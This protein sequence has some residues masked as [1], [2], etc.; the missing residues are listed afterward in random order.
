MAAGVAMIVLPW[1][2]LEMRTVLSGSMEPRLGQGDL[3]VAWPVRADRIEPGDVILF[4]DGDHAVA[5]RVVAV[6]G[7]HGAR[8]FET[9]GDANDAADEHL[10]PQSDVLGRMVFYVPHAGS[11][12]EHLRAPYGSLALILIPCIA[13]LALDG[14]SWLRRPARATPNATSVAPNDPPA[15]HTHAI[16]AQPPTRYARQRVVIATAVT[17]IAVVIVASAAI[18]F[19]PRDRTEIPAPQLASLADAA[20]LVLQS[21]VDAIAHDPS[22]SDRSSDHAPA[23]ERYGRDAG[24]ELTTLAVVDLDGEVLAATGEPLATTTDSGALLRALATGQPASMPMRTIEGLPYVDA[25]APIL[26]ASG[27]TTGVLLA[28]VGASALWRDAIAV[29][30]G[31][32]IIDGDGAFFVAPAGDASS[33]RPGSDG[34]TTAPLS[35]D[36]AAVWS[37]VSCDTQSSPYPF[38]RRGITVLAI[39]FI[40]VGG[41]AAAFAWVFGLLPGDLTPTGDLANERLMTLRDHANEL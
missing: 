2:G 15:P 40:A 31:A 39:A 6:S 13:L 12:A 16:E 5:H 25:A 28:R 10:V 37:V 7:E 38:D 33:L 27:T 18:V 8:L 17:G 1:F 34:C 20:T 21:R 9:K 24:V 32:A 14:A 35:L 41:S 3:L 11:L 29:S 22:L 26:D 4:D 30:D 36:E 19:T 23:L